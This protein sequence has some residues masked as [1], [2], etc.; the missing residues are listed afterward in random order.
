MSLKGKTVV[1]TG[2][3]R[4]LGLDM[5]QA[6][7]REGADVALTYITSDPTEL[8]EKVEAEHGVKCRAYKVQITDGP[9]VQQ[10]VKQIH[11][12]FGRLDVFVAN[13]GVTA[14]ANAEYMDFDAWKHVFDVNVHGVYYGVQAAGK[15]MIEQGHGNIIL[16]SSI[17]ASIA[18]IPQPQCAYNCSKAAVSMMAKC[19]AVEWAPHN[20][21]VNA[22][23]PGYHATDMLGNIFK[24]EPQ[25]E[26][27]WVGLT[28]QRRLGDPKELA[29]VIAF[30]ASD[31]C[32][33]ITGTELFVDGGY[34]AI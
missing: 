26:R 24:K 21:R 15:I 3:A 10:V 22:L 29:N 19:L 9:Q 33:F 27:D 7:A 31:K 34:T 30:L 20:I 14:Q 28:P 8:C 16:V 12:D 1:V 6:L 4:G 13:A 25:L 17:S 32:T 18:N 5:T 23:C 2:G 11:A